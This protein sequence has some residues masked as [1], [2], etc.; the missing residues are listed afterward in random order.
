[1][2]RRVALR[3]REILRV[4]VTDAHIALGEGEAVVGSAA[5][6]PL[7]RRAAHP[8]RRD[9]AGQ[10]VA[11]AEHR[12]RLGRVRVGTV[13]DS[14]LAGVNDGRIGE[15]DRHV[16]AGRSVLLEE[17]RLADAQEG[18]VGLLAIQRIGLQPLFAPADPVGAW[19]GHD[20]V[21][22]RHQVGD[23]RLAR[24]WGQRFA[25]RFVF[26]AGHDGAGDSRLGRVA[27]TD[28]RDH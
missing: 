11:A 25:V 5:V 26:R 14:C 27:H 3:E 23:H 18:V 7:I 19:C 22:S 8:L 20:A 1:M 9:Q 2:T 6:E 21:P 10:R 13:A 15:A 28:P 17:A 24:Q 12:A 16:V 4:R